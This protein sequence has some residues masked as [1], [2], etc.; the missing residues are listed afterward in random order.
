[1][2]TCSHSNR[3]SLISPRFRNIF[4]NSC[5]GVFLA[6]TF[7]TG[8]VHA[9]S[10]EFDSGLKGTFD[11]TLTMGIAWRAS[12]PNCA[13]IGQDNGGCASTSLV[14]LAS[15]NP[16]DFYQTYDLLRINQ[17]DGNLNY[18]RG[19]TVSSKVLGSHEL[20]LKYTDGWSALLRAS[21]AQDFSANDTQRTPLADDARQQATREFRFM[22]AYV[23]KEFDLGGV[24][25]RVRVG[26]Q[27][28]NWGESLFIPGGVS[29]TNAID[30]TKLHSPGA[31]LKEVQVPAPML[32][33]NLRLAKGLS[34][35][36]YIQTGW[37]A[38]RLDPAGTFFSTSDFIGKGARGVFLPTSLS[39]NILVSQGYPTVPAG[40]V[41]D[42]GTAITSI[43]PVT[44]NPVTSRY[45]EAQL[46]SALTNPLYGPVTGTGSVFPQ[47]GE[48]TPRS[49][50]QWGISL[51]YLDDESGNEWGLYYLR[52]HD[53]LPTIDLLVD[54]ASGANPFSYRGISA[55][56]A[57][58]RSLI[59]ATYNTR[60][61]EWSLGYEASYRPNEVISIDP[62]AVI[63]PAN[64]Y[65][66]N[67]DLNPANY[68]ADGT[69]C[70]GSVERQK[71]QFDISALH[72]LQPSGSLGGLLKLT[73]A[74]EGSLLVEVAAAHYPDL[75]KGAPVP[76]AVTNDYR[77]PTQT[78]VGL[79][80][81]LT[82]TYPNFA[83]SGWTLIQDT[84]LSYGVSG[85]SAS[86]LPGFI[87]GVGSL[88]LGFTVDFRTPTSTKLRI[89]YTGNFGGALSNSMRDRNW[90]GVSLSA[91]F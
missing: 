76:F 1:M 16:S 2:S 69:R 77:M 89:N 31:Q 49:S 91:S 54:Y 11:S 82:L 51:R 30:V 36:G 67:G 59:G 73:G 19:Q 74:A 21:W 24:S 72:L 28:M 4:Q 83:S 29:A 53:K 68:I 43:D 84:T 90:L 27:V 15:R 86:A 38:S 42:T 8:A 12:S 63:N 6:A 20:A 88:G 81:Q 62:S 60:L 61:G 47:S 78:S 26:N 40:S 70:K 58:D 46:T 71:W 44:G 64:P 5:R 10:F 39:N 80:S 25:G 23:G 7:G 56:Y 17:D 33:L 34:A 55:H 41:G 18:R 52:Y 87:E 13:Y 35:E 85:I 48:Q 50:G 66:C 45:T 57:S 65:Y 9:A 32:S 79:V 37:N 75:F 22:D 14:E 3:S